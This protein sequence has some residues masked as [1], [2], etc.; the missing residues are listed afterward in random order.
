MTTTMNCTTTGETATALQQTS[1]MTSS[2][3]LTSHNTRAAADQNIAVI[4]IDVVRVLYLA[5]GSLGIFNN[6]CVIV[7]IASSRTLRA[8]IRNWFILNQSVADCCAAVVIMGSVTKTASTPLQ[9]NIHPHH[10]LIRA[11][12]HK[13][14][15][16]TL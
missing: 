13:G 8:H 10:I 3:A 2:S 11:Y 16:V 9:V 7:V 15:H 14:D 5:I 12:V 6:I 1:S 4:V